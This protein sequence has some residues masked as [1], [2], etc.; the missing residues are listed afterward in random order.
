MAIKKIRKIPPVCI[1]VA[2]VKLF[3]GC[4]KLTVE[5]LGIE[6]K[7]EDG[8]VFR[9]FRNIKAQKQDSSFDS[10]VF[11]VSFKFARLS[12]KANEVASFLPMML[13][14]GFPGFIQ[15]MYAVND[16]SGYWMGMYEWKSKQHLDAYKKSLVFRMM[17]KRAVNESVSMM[18]ARNSVL[19]GYIH[20]HQK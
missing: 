13:I 1:V 5:Y 18:E 9:V 10:C 4:L 19:E 2:F 11:V 12:H 7:Y 14:A 8:N 16:Q 17:N 6:L 20:H 15:K 3:T